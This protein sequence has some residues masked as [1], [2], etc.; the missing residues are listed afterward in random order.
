MGDVYPCC[1][2]FC[3]LMMNCIGGDRDL[4]RMGMA[5]NLPWLCNDIALRCIIGLRNYFAAE[6]NRFLYR[7]KV[8]DEIY[9]RRTD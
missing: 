3:W 9:Y 1:D 5:C 7:S 8:S 4:G 2:G 6:T